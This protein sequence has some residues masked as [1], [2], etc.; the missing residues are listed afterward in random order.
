VATLSRS[1]GFVV[2]EH[3]AAG[4]QAELLDDLFQVFRLQAPIDA[5]CSEIVKA[6]S[7]K[8]HL[9]PQRRDA[10]FVVPA[11]DRQQNAALFEDAQRLNKAAGPALG[12]A[13]RNIGLVRED[14]APERVVEVYRD[15]LD[16]IDLRQSPVHRNDLGPYRSHELGASNRIVFAKRL[17]RLDP[18]LVV[19]VEIV[20]GHA[21]MVER[22]QGVVLAM[23]AAK[24]GGDGIDVE[25][26]RVAVLSDFGAEHGV[27]LLD[28]ENRIA[29][30]VARQQAPHRIL[31]RN[32]EIRDVSA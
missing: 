9:V 21:G 16:L 7:A 18:P 15:Q 4:Q 14:A 17:R 32:E 26:V 25:E 23:F 1:I 24:R 8:H 27:E 22:P 28:K 30:V 29:D 19:A 12:V 31:L 5:A 11:H 6:Q 2:D 3:D 20:A 10:F 13:G